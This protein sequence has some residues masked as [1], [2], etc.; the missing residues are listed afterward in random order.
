L[1]RLTAIAVR[2]DDSSRA[3]R[4][5]IMPSVGVPHG[6]TNWVAQTQASEKKCYPPYYYFQKTFQ[7][8]RASRWMNGSCT[9]DYGSVT[10]MPLQGKLEVSPENRASA[11]SHENEVATPSYYSVVLEDYHIKAELTGLSGENPGEERGRR[12]KGKVLHRPAQCTF[13]PSHL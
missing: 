5:Q 10:I 12:T 1:H 7:G 3:E 2:P 9:Q 8:F 6:M 4:G 13:P 11:F